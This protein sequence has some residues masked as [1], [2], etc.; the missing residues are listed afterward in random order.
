MKVFISADI[1]GVA[2]ITAKEEARKGQAG[3]PPFR[4]QMEAEVA[5]ACEGAFAAGP[6]EVVVKD[7]HGDG[8]NLSPGALPVP[9]RLIRGYNGHPF[10]MV[11]GLDGSFDAALFVGY[12]SRAGSGGNPLAHTL[13]STKVFGMRL[14]GRPLSEHW[15]HVLAA[16]TV[17]VPV[18]LVTGDRALCEE[19]AEL[20]PSCRTVA[21]SEGEGASTRSLH[22][23]A[24]VTA[25][26]TAAEEA[27]NGP[28]PPVP[29]VLGPHRLEIT[30]HDAGAAY[31]RSQYPGAALVDDHTVAIE[32][33]D[34]FD[35]LRALIFL[36]GL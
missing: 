34:F 35:V 33:D 14:N 32:Q 36:V 12:R 30:Y 4:A 26:R 18:V 29:S 22:P 16:A 11:Q 31:V 2:G 28:R 13:S 10:A 27:L 17:G 19:V 23:A 15:I 7:A 1:E 25:I 20:A 8:R 21:V 3:Y 9:A 6:T 24:A 5:A